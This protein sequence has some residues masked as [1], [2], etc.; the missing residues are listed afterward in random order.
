MGRERLDIMDEQ[1][2]ITCL[3]FKQVKASFLAGNRYIK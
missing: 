1:S 3:E 2:E